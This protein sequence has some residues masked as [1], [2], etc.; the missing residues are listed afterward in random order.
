MPSSP[1]IPIEIDCD[2]VPQQY[3]FGRWEDALR[4]WTANWVKATQF[5]GV[6]TIFAVAMPSVN[7]GNLSNSAFYVAVGLPKAYRDFIAIQL[8]KQLKQAVI[9][10]SDAVIVSTREGWQARCQIQDA[11]VWEPVDCVTWQKVLAQ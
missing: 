2:N 7:F 8:K 9:A 1:Q 3:A 10:Q 5:E 6:A 11:Q 4:T